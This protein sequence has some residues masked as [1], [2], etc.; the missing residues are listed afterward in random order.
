M[1]GI[2][3]RSVEARLETSGAKSSSAI[4]AP[5]ILQSLVNYRGIDEQ[6]IPQLDLQNEAIVAMASGADTVSCTLCLAV[7]HLASN[8]RVY[9]KLLDEI[10]TAVKAGNLSD[11]PKFEETRKLEYLDAVIQELIRVHPVATISCTHNDF[12]CRI[13]RRVPA[14]KAS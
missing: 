5:D 3:E 6:R 9:S 14:Q 12:F 8:S 2:A 10:E 13:Y 7:L 1:F 11:P 4:N